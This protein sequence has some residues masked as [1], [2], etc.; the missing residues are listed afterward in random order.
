M[1]IAFSTYC[2]DWSVVLANEGAPYVF[3]LVIITAI[4]Y[5]TWRVNLKKKYFFRLILLGIR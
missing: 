1:A 3:A 4:N 5:C 2:N